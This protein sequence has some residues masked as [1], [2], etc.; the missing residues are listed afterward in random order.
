MAIGDALTAPTGVQNQ[1]VGQPSRVP[2]YDQGYAQAPG[3]PRPTQPNPMGRPTAVV[4]GPAYFTPEGYNAP[5]QPTQAF[6]PTDRAPDPIGDQ[7]MRQ[8]QSPM[9]QQ[10]QQQYEAT[11]API[12]E[13]EMAQRAEQQAAQDARFQEMMDRIAELEGQLSQPTEPTEPTPPTTPMPGDDSFINLPDF[14]GNL[15]FSG[16][17]ANL[18]NLDFDQIIKQ[19]QDRMNSGEPEPINTFI[20]EAVSNQ[21][22]DLGSVYAG[23]SPGF[24]DNMR[25]NMS[26]GQRLEPTPA[27]SVVPTMPEIPS[28]LGTGKSVA[29][30]FMPGGEGV[31]PLPVPET[32]NIFG[33][34]YPVSIGSGPMKEGSFLSAVPRPDLPIPNISGPFGFIGTSQKTENPLPNNSITDFLANL[35]TAESILP[36]PTPVM[37]ALT[38][39]PQIPN[40]PIQQPMNFTGLPNIPAS[41]VIQPRVED[42]IAPI[43]TGSTRRLPQPGLFNLR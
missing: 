28:F 35:G 11:Q 25:E 7:F 42:I 36:A 15:D 40:F 30:S 16:L 8:M 9:G 33:K 39:I 32:I 3:M 29:T 23:G 18:G 41:S 38:N 27:P 19:Y 26:P 24:Y 20:E 22:P 6:M 12:R 4:G 17:P 43:R 14:L 37:P 21:E 34:T 10:Y 13:A 31:E 5:P 1:M 2:G